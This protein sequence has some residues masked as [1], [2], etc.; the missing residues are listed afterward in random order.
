MPAAAL[1]RVPGAT[2]A[3]VEEVAAVIERLVAEE[4][5]ADIAAEP[6]GPPP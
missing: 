5:P 3:A 1:D 2:T 6:D 4:L